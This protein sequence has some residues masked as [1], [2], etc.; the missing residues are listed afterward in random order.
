MLRPRTDESA[1]LNK[2]HL[3][4]SGVWI[5]Y[6]IVVVV[7]GFMRDV[8]SIRLGGIALLGLAILKVFLYDLNSSSSR[9]ASLASRSWVLFCS[10]PLTC[11]PGIGR[12][13]SA[14]LLLLL[15]RRGLSSPRIQKR[16][17]RKKPVGMIFIVACEVGIT[18]QSSGRATCVT[19]IVYQRTTSRRMRRSSL[20]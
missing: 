18:G 11:T 15:L 16:V 17:P 10:V 13:S 20:A 1:L 5:L 12:S 7:I 4:L 9:T 8:R 2:L 3:V 6:G 14:L 19:P